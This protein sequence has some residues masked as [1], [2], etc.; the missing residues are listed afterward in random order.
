MKEDGHFGVS[1]YLEF[2]KGEEAKLTSSSTEVRWTL[3]GFTNSCGDP[4]LRGIIFVGEN[5]TPLER[6]GI[7]I[8]TKRIGDNPWH[9]ILDD[10][11]YGPGKFYRS[12]PT[13]SFKGKEVSTYVTCSSK[14]S[15][16]S[17]ILAEMLKQINKTGILP[18]EPNGPTSFL[19]LDGHD[20]RLDLP[21]LNYINNQEKKWVVC[22]GLPNGMSLWQVGDASQ[23]NE[24][25]K[26]CYAK[27]KMELIKFKQDHN[28]FSKNM[29]RTDIVPIMN[30]AWKNGFAKIESN[31]R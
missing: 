21:F 3:L 22:L 25:Y 23:Q 11:N 28:V 19:L 5:L 18:R 29:E 31:Q 8:T 12:P 2:A 17:D 4:I 9:A 15:I 24:C 27:R 30:H 6:L 20:S 1:K 14:G 16:T 7:D 26:M 10:V 13:C